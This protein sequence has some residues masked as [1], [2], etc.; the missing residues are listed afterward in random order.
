M[1]IRKILPEEHMEILKLRS[2]S[3][4]SKKDF[5]DPEKVKEDYEAVRALFDDTGRACTTARIEPFNVRFN[6]RNIKLG[7]IGAIATLPRERNKGYVRKMFNFCFEEMRENG[8]IWSCLFPFSHTYYRM[9]G[10]ECC[11]DRQCVSMPLDAFA[12]LRAP[13]YAEQLVYDENIADVKEVYNHYIAD[14]NF[15]VVRDESQWKEMFDCD[16]YTE[17]IS[18]YIW[19]TPE[20]EAV[21]YISYDS[22]STLQHEM[23]VRELAFKNYDG[24]R[25][26]L[27]FL[28]RFHPVFK[29][30]KGSLPSDIDFTILVS[31]PLFVQ[32]G[33]NTFGM[34]RVVDAEKVL[35][36]IKPP[37][38]NGRVTIQINDGSIPWNNDCFT[39][40]FEDGTV[41]VTRGGTEADLICDANVLARFASGH[42]SLEK[43]ALFNT[44][45]INSNRELLY[46]IFPK[47]EI[48]F[49]EAY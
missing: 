39:L 21:S 17:L 44:V 47:K 8:Q 10:Y 28:S 29:A 49:T 20:G 14:K 12:D 16:P 13:G 5:S 15:A 18:T 48:F 26:L 25:G 23:A 9:F 19:Y 46:S 35:A 30:L 31:E 45:Q 3:Y 22:S 6:G 43:E 42:T 41:N 33:L 2:A 40:S 7:G 38:Q 27:G 1:E 24:L 32:R 34:N 11:Y 36:L 4:N 37:S